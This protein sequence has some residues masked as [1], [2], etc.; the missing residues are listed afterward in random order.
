MKHLIYVDEWL[1]K[2]S[3]AL[4][5]DVSCRCVKDNEILNDVYNIVGAVMVCVDIKNKSKSNKTRCRT[6]V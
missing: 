6:K 1:I 5:L 4:E 3:K 2:E